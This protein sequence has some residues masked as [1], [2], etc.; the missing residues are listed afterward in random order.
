MLCEAGAIKACV[1]AL[2]NG[3]VSLSVSFSGILRSVL[4]GSD[5]REGHNSPAAAAARREHAAAAGAI[6]KTPEI[7][8]SMCISETNHGSIFT[9][10][11]ALSCLSI[12]QRRS[13]ARS[14]S[15]RK[16]L[17]LDSRCSLSD[18]RTEQHAALR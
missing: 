18:R 17:P 1:F 5:G 12:L 10:L 16:H 7:Q 8:M 3:D 13:S 14:S 9:L 15:L 6:G 2:E 4:F 11:A